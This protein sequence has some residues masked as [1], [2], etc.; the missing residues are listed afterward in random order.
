MFPHVIEARYL[1]GYTIWLRFG[2]G[3]C[4]EVDLSGE[5]EGPVFGP[6]RD[7]E[8]FKRFQIA[9]HTLAWDDGA[10][11]APELLRAQVRVTV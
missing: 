2:D 8:R 11:L 6:L 1:H 9:H 4:G 5:L 10:D 7:L 3:A